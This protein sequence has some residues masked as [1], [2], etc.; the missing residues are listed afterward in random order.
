LNQRPRFSSSTI[1]N[2]EYA[3]YLR[4]CAIHLLLARTPEDLPPQAHNAR[5]NSVLLHWRKS[6]LSAMFFI[7]R[8]AN[9]QVIPH[10]EE[11]MSAIVF[12]GSTSEKR[13]IVDQL[14]IALV[15]RG[16]TTT[17]W[18]ASEAFKLST[19]TVEGLLD[20]ARQ[21]DFG[22]FILTPDDITTS[23]TKTTPTARA[24]VVFEYGLFLGEMGSRRAF[25]IM[26]V[27][28]HLS[29]EERLVLPSD[30]YGIHIPQFSYR[31]T[32]E[33]AGQMR[34]IATRILTAIDDE[35]LKTI[36]LRSKWNVIPEQRKF[37]VVLSKSRINAHWS[38]LREK[39]IVLAFR[40]RR[41]PSPSLKTDNSI[42]I[43]EAFDIDRDDDLSIE[44]TASPSLTFEPGDTFDGYIFLV[45]RRSVI[46]QCTTI[47][48]LF[49]QGCIKAD[50]NF[51]KT[52]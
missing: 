22:I 23:R 13:E 1:A 47:Q 14:E 11:S 48:Q 15:D 2:L 9:G 30:L 3:R 51:G 41:E 7:I 18:F 32:T 6:R 12:V 39:K 16:V 40:K 34:V 17:P 43:G 19:S 45:P 29:P 38:R 28:P 5:W 25:A 27:P 44:A 24:N 31:D 52:I 49:G 42:V 4:R 46:T 37:T 8:V 35:G 10:W 33:L 20:A 21:S 36:R 26:E 50:H